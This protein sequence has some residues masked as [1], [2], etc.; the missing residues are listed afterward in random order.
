MSV[1][2]E[3]L[4][5]VLFSVLPITLMVLLL[6]F[7]LTPIEPTM[8]ARFLAGAA[9]MIVGLTVFLFGVDV[10]ITP[11]GNEMGASIVKQ[12]TLKL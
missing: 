9:L 4:R 1:I 10:G 5:E 2:I 7:T 11:I 8:L 3:K 12:A 6:H